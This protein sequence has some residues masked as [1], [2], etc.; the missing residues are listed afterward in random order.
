VSFSERAVQRIK[1]RRQKVQSWFL[2][3]NLVMDYWGAQ[4][5]R[6]YHHT[7]PVNALYALHESLLMLEE[8][9]LAGSHKRHALHHQALAAGFKAMGLSLPVMPE[10]RLPQLNAVSVPAGVEE[11]KIRQLLLQDWNLE[12]GAGLGSLAGK[13]WRVGLMGHTAS[14]QN[15]IFCLS[16]MEQALQS[17]AANIHVACALPAAQQVY[18]QNE[19]ETA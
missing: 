9:G 17:Q 5:R 3:M 8:E 1:S 16:A 19:S 14:R 12:I 4:T 2:D 18:N 13:V 6:S 10:Y 11:A 7:A 15:V